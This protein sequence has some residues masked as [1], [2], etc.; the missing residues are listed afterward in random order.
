MKIL[1]LN[2][3][4]AYNPNLAGFLKNTL[5][6]EEYDFVLL[7]EATEPV[8]NIVRNVGPYALLEAFSDEFQMQSHL[9][10]L[11][12]NTFV[13]KDSTLFCYGR[14]HP[15]VGLQH[16]GFGILLG[17]FNVDGREVH[18]GSVHLHSGIRPGVRVEELH[19]LKKHLFPY[20]NN[21]SLVM[22]GGDFNFGFPGELRRACEILAPEFCCKTRTLGP[23]LNSRYTELLPNIVNKSAYYLKKIGLGISLRADHFFVNQRTAMQSNIV[24]HILPNRVS[25]HSPVELTLE[26]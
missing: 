6:S 16:A 12:R 10:I 9:S 2:T 7:Q 26:S 24:T 25:D 4:K 22:F 13:L 19:L 20:T 1:S 11:Y 23:T 14:T 5:E 21:D 8:L 3:Q 15:K 17:T 18:I